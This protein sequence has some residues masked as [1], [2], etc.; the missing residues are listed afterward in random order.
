MPAAEGVVAP[1]DGFLF[2]DADHRV[3]GPVTEQV[4]G[5]PCGDD[6]SLCVVDGDQHMRH[7]RAV[8]RA[9]TDQTG[10]QS[11]GL[12]YA[13]RLPGL[14]LR[15]V[16][17]AELPICTTRS[18]TS[19]S[20]SSWVEMID[21]P[22]GVGDRPQRRSHRFDLGV[23]EVRGRLVGE[24][25]GWVV[26]KRAC[27]RHPLLLPARQSAWAVTEALRQTEVR[28]AVPWRGRGPS[29]STRRRR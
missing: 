5:G 26:G 23:V 27:D 16:R 15:R 3:I 9:A 4:V 18:A 7:A 14:D 2:G 11:D 25:D 6:R 12:E 29:G 28:Q 1:V 13:V 21:D 24:H 10:Q 20:R 17:R 19:P 8:P 22:P